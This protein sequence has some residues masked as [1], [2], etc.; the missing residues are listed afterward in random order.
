MHEYYCKT[1][2][3]LF[4]NSI[5]QSRC[6]TFKCQSRHIKEINTSQKGVTY[7]NF[8]WRE[9]D[10]GQKTRMYRDRQGRKIRNMQVD[11]LKKELKDKQQP[12]N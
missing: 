6:P 2:R 12:E 8:E 11:W 4:E 10:E 5:S 1:C 9:A 3:L 7:S